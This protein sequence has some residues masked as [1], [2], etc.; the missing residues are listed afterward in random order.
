MKRILSAVLTVSMAFTL[1]VL[2][3]ASA[4]D[5]VITLEPKKSMEDINAKWEKLK[6]T[7]KGY[8]LYVEDAFVY[9]WEPDSFKAGQ[10]A[11]EPKKD[12]LNLVNFARYLADVPSD[13]VA[14]KEYETY[15]Q[16]GSALLLCDGKLTHTPK[17]PNSVP[18]DFYKKGYKGASGSN[19]F[20]NPAERSPN[21]VIPASVY[22]YLN[23]SDSSNI[24]NVGHRRWILN[25]KMKA[26]GFGA[27]R[28]T[29][30]GLLVSAMYVVDASG[31]SKNY[32][33]VTWPAV[34]YHPTKFFDNDEAW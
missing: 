24:A 11:E 34:G 26:T 16:Y 12:G 32:D 27:A 4:A 6:P 33:C 23:D 9:G 1:F 25:P 28:D 20:M 21:E 2:P 13:V 14:K 7:Y 19:L 3:T 5:S 29:W 15:A 10:I 31:S 18:D 8:V 22:G 17:K 30:A